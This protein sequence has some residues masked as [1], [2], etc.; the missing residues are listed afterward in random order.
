M[1]VPVK[2]KNIL[3]VFLILN[4]LVISGSAAPGIDS[5]V[6]VRVYEKSW[7]LTVQKD[8]LEVLL[9]TIYQDFQV[10]VLGLESRKKE[11]ITLS[12]TGKSL[13]DIIRSLLLY[14]G[15]KNFAFEFVDN[16][17]KRVL[18]LPEANSD[19]RN[20]SS[21]ISAQGNNRGK[22]VNAVE[23]QGIIDGSQAKKLDF[24]KG[25]LIIEYDGI[26]INRA[27]ELIE[28]TK[29][30]T[31]DEEIEILLLRNGDFVRSKANGGFI[32]VQVKTIK[33]FRE[34]LEGT[35]GRF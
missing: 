27:M 14:L 1:S 17:L 18:V 24:R 29:K 2:Y 35:S 16:R 6:T 25:D 19:I 26:K 31:P 22:S 34:E 8:L 12:V 28:E 13:A 33:I 7:E 20:L 9:D 23:I 11:S 30:R 4:Y 10:E 5:S 15:E 32:G 21:A 3:W